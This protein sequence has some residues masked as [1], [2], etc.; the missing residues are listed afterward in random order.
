MSD[1]V[2]SLDDALSEAGEAVILRR[3]VGTG[4]AAVNIDVTVRAAVRKL[5]ADELVGTLS[6]TD[7]MVV[8]S[9]TQILTAQW[10]GGTPVSAAIHQ[11]DPRIPKIGDKLIIKGKVRDVILSK[12]IFVGD[13]WVRCELVAK[14]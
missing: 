14:G 8:I 9:P 4:S 13:E 12:P 1:Y 2:A 3:I 5:S 6:Q 10:P 7:D 11:E